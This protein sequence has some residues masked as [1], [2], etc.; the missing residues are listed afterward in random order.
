MKTYI[1]RESEI[2]KKWYLIDAEGKVL[3][4]IAA[5]AAKLLR[6]KHKPYFTPF[7]DCGDHVIIIN[8]EKAVVTGNKE[9][10]KMYYRH[11]GYKGGLKQMTY[12]QMI[13][14]HPTRAMELAVWGMLPHNRLGRKIVKHLKVYAGS[15]HKHQAQNPEVWEIKD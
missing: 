11:S 9:E 1:P 3:G 2:K 14:R 4:R 15:E 5:E 10:D 6:G 7:M 12:R 8:A 13:E